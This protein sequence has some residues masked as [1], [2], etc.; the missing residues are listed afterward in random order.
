MYAEKSG[1]ALHTAKINFS[2]HFLSGYYCI[3]LQQQYSV[4][5]NSDML[6]IAWV[7]KI[8]LLVSNIGGLYFQHVKPYH[9]KSLCGILSKYHTYVYTHVHTYIQ[10]HTY[11]YVRTYTHTSK[12]THIYTHTFIHMQTLIKK[13]YWDRTVTTLFNQI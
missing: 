13:L 1:H 11:Y 8:V 6:I 9:L 3:V 2:D 5:S 7:E 12:H 4:R 10:K